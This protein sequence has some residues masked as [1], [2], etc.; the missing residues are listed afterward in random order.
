MHISALIT[1]E[2][3]V[4]FFFTVT[5]REQSF[6]LKIYLLTLKFLF[7]CCA[8]SSLLHRLSL[9]VESRG[10][11]C[12]SSWALGVWAAVAGAYGLYS[13]GLVGAQCMACGIFLDQGLNPCPL[14]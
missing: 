12:C 1:I 8:G 9:V 14:H 2:C 13:V 7:F 4:F 6:F 5:F 3:F 11:S 10:F